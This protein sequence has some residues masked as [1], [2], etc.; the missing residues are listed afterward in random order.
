[1]NVSPPQ[2]TRPDVVQHEGDAEREQHLPQLVAAHEAQQALV[3]HDPPSRA[4]NAI[5]A[6]APTTKLPVQARDRI[7]D[8]A[9]EQVE[10][11][12]RQ[13]H[14]PE[15]AEDQREARMRR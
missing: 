12:M 6:S 5:A 1:M 8:E 7:A 11:A 14:D 15:Q 10:R 13:V 3:E 4:T 2:M 9:A